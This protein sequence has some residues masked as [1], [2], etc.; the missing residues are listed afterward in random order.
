MERASPSDYPMTWINSGSSYR[1]NSVTDLMTYLHPD[2]GNFINGNSLLNIE[3]YEDAMLYTVEVSRIHL[4]RRDTTQGEWIFAMGE[5]NLQ[6]RMLC[7]L[8]LHFNGRDI[9]IRSL[10]FWENGIV[11]AQMRHFPSHSGPLRKPG[12]GALPC[13]DCD[14][15]LQASSIAC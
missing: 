4:I 8:T 12:E 7:G 9:K 1:P 5:T 10:E 6:G 2:E 3:S 13:L 15:I 14:R 11:K